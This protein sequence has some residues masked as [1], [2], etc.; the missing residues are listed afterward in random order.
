MG[1]AGVFP[2]ASNRVKYADSMK[3]VEEQL[4]INFGAVKGGASKD[5]ARSV[6]AIA[7][8]MGPTKF[9]REMLKEI[10]DYI[11]RYKATIDTFKLHYFLFNDMQNRPHPRISSFM[12]DTTLPDM[13]TGDLDILLSIRCPL[14]IKPTYFN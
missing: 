8:E 4:L 1:N 13:R 14:S 10:E 12:M 5:F 11:P 7:A 6:Q 9:K 2:T 3:S